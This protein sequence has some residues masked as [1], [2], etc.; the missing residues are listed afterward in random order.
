[1]TGLPDHAGLDAD[2]VRGISG[3]G[4][5]VPLGRRVDLPGR[6]TTFVREAGSPSAPFTVLL[7]HG[8]LASAGLN[9]AASFEPLGEH[10]RVVAADLRGH[11]RGIR[12]RRRFRLEDCADDLGALVDELGCGPVIVVGYSMGGLVSPAAVAT[13]S[14]R[15]G[16][17]RPLLDDSH[18]RAAVGASATS[19][20]PR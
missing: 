17:P 3:N 4:L 19:S 16:G 7:V 20:A 9:W 18:L 5:T 8:W 2:A 11:G 10:F 6:G 12:T 14:R 15:G 1:M 13:P